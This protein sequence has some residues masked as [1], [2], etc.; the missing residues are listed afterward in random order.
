MVREGD[1]LCVVGAGLLS[2]FGELGRFEREAE[3]RPFDLAAIAATPFDTSSYQDVL[4]VAASTDL[5]LGSLS[6]WL[7]GFGA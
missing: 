2:S 3:L 6:R 5:L 7:E 1:A 4:F